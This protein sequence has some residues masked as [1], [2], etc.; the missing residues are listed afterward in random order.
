MSVRDICSAAPALREGKSWQVPLLDILA[1]QP[2][3]IPV[4][5]VWNSNTKMKTLNLFLR[6]VRSITNINVYKCLHV[7]V[8]GYLVSLG[9]EYMSQ[10]SCLISR[11]CTKPGMNFYSRRNSAVQ[12]IG[13]M[14]NCC[15]WICLLS[16]YD[17][18]IATREFLSHAIKDLAAGTSVLHIRKDGFTQKDKHCRC[19]VYIFGLKW[20]LRYFLKRRIKSYCEKWGKL[21]EIWSKTLDLR[22]SYFSVRY[23][24]N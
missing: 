10:N 4:S 24:I 2:R 20:L 23:L 12:P 3:H 9:N 19:S 17:Q 1:V 8:L 5:Q 15:P 22:N 13:L 21:C 6:Y 16:S 14:S 11:D 7:S 18:K